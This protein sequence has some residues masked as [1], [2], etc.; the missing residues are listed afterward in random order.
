MIRALVTGELRADPQQRVAKNGNPFALARL[1]V[2]MGDQ[3]R[4]S[5]SLI[6]FEAEAVRRMMQMRAGAQ[7]AAAGA[8]KVGTYTAADGTSRPSLD[9]V[10]DEV[11]SSAP[12]PKKPRAQAAPARQAQHQSDPFGDLPGGGEIEWEA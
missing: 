6:A 4:I 5:C 1:S 12:R 2:P 8:L 3:G 9:L 7:V 11:A 10:A